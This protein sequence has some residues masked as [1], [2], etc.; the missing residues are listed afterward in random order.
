MAAAVRNVEVEVDH[1]REAHEP[2]LQDDDDA[3]SGGEEV[4]DAVVFVGQTEDGPVPGEVKEEQHDREGIIDAATVVLFAFHF[5]AADIA[6]VFQRNQRFERKNAF[7][8]KHVAATAIRAFAGNEAEDG[9][10]LGRHIYAKNAASY[11][12]PLRRGDAE[13]FHH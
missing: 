6:T 3:D 13:N 5:L 8:Q 12:L 10:W 2:G 11:I 4:I 7:V 1:P 9:V